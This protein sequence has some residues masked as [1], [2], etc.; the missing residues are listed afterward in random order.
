MVLQETLIVDKLH[1][2]NETHLLLFLLQI[3]ILV[4][5]ARGTGLW[6]H[7]RGQP[8]ISGEILVGI[9]LGPTLM[10]RF[11]PG[12]YHWLFPKD[13]IQSAMLETMAW[14]GILFF[15]LVAGLE[16]DFKLA[17]KRKRDAAIISIAD[18]IIPMA[19]AFVP[20]MFLPQYYLGEA[21]SRSLFAFFIATILTISALPVT[22]RA[23][24]DLRIFKSDVGLL[25]MT[26]LTINDV[27]GWIVFAVIL[28][29]VGVGGLT[30]GGGLTM[31]AATLIFSVVA[32][33]LGHTLLE[34]MLI[35][36][37]KRA[38]PEPGTSLSI[39]FIL[40]CLGGVVTLKIG[41]HALFGF[42]LAGMVAG[43]TIHIS[44]RSRHIIDE[45]VRSF[46]VPLFFATVALRIDFVSKFDFFLAA[47]IT[48]I[49]FL[50]RYAGAWIGV[51]LTKRNIGDR[52]II[53]VAHTPGGEMQIVVGLLALEANIITERVFVAIVFGAIATS[54]FLGPFMKRALAS[55]RKKSC[56][57]VL[58]KPV[59]SLNINATTKQ[60]ALEYVC[61]LAGSQVPNSNTSSLLKDVVQR[62]KLQATA[63]GNTIAIPHGRAAW[64]TRPQI[65]VATLAR[66]V[67]WNAPDGLRVDWVLLI[68]TSH[69]ED[70]SQVWLTRNLASALSEEEIRTALKK[71]DQPQDFTKRLTEAFMKTPWA[72][73]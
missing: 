31:L 3:A 35:A 12:F 69:I 50:G 33:G 8:S 53:A 70:G 9:V 26:A 10:G 66:P 65:V 73:S 60:E 55:L 71:C 57:D 23:M 14:L 15:L 58:Q 6:L 18:L 11:F 22:V 56:L 48:I 38:Y 2:L 32:I 34:R 36:L 43:S 29:A 1:Y 24:Q 64:C 40:G 5:L 54:I 45:T 4:A 63:I 7:R 25:I 42:F 37:H 17:L 16:T 30:I 19:I 49:G 13:P 47:F 27:L 51:W 61:A 41:I 67:E 20:C 44:E 21:A 59:V 39:L 62:E 72:A 68:V 46:L 52:N 28:G